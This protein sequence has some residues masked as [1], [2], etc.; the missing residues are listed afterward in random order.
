MV[1]KLLVPAGLAHRLAHFDET[2]DAGVVAQEM[3]VHVHDEL[4]FKRVRS[5]LGHRR[6]RGFRLGH[7]EQRSI[8]LV[9]RD[10]GCGH[11]GRGLEKSATIQTLLAAEI[12][13]HGE[14]PRLDL[15]L[16][17]ILRIG[18]EFVAGNNP[19]RNRRLVLK[20]FG[21]HQRGKFFFC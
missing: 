21:R 3:R 20:H 12:V 17:L 2:H 4:V 1:G 6:R 16:P 7:V 11:A 5:L 8:D 14:H 13:G 15:A 18:I 10:K 19:G 9:H